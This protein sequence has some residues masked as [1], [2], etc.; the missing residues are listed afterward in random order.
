MWTGRAIRRCRRCRMARSRSRWAPAPRP[1]RCSTR[2]GSPHGAPSLS[3]DTIDARTRN[4][5]GVFFALPVCRRG[6]S[7]R[8]L[9]SEWPIR[10]VLRV[11]SRGAA[12][13]LS[14][15]AAA[16]ARLRSEVDRHRRSGQRVPHQRRL[17]RRQGLHLRRL[18]R[19]AHRRR[20]RPPASPRAT[21]RRVSTATRGRPAARAA[22]APR[23]RRAPPTRPARRR[24]A[25]R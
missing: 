7:W 10:L 2:A 11:G 21:A 15:G 25:A 22:P 18:R 17:H 6:V 4:G 24:C 14:L 13:A 5:P 16:R 8:T 3:S 12:L 9:G 23:A 19:A 20:G 1:R